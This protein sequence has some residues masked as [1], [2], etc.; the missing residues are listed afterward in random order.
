[1]AC[2]IFWKREKREPGHG[3]GFT[4]L[5][6]LVDPR[7]MHPCSDCPLPQLRS[8]HPFSLLSWK[9]YYYTVSLLYLCTDNALRVEELSSLPLAWL[10]QIKKLQFRNGGVSQ[11]NTTSTSQLSPSLPQL[12]LTISIMVLVPSGTVICSSTN[13]VKTK[14]QEFLFIYSGALWTNL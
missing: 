13:Q 8:L 1:M 3:L 10:I 5:L 2:W 9:T 4:A 6:C 12:S 11:N 14:W 7:G